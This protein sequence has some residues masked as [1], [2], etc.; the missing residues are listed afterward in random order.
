MKEIYV[1]HNAT[2]YVRG[3]VLDVMLPY[4][5]EEYGNAS[6][7]YSVGR[8]AKQAIEE[9]RKKV[10]TAI[11]AKPHEIYFVASGTE[12]DNLALKGIVSANTA[13]G[14]HIITSR[15][16]HPAILKTCKE[17]EKQGVTVTYLDVDEEGFVDLNQLRYSITDKTVLISIMTA[18][19]E[20]GTIQNIEEIGKI[21]RFKDVYFHTDSVQAIGNLKI[22]VKEMNID[23]L[24][25]SAH[26]FYGPKGIGVLYMKKGIGFNP[27]ITGR[28]SR[29][30]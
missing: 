24:S 27:V 23:A 17:L 22:D 19:N 20:I 14:S 30:K 21:A 18:N 2:T 9:A 4:F 13:K 28:A 8:R 3:E 12:A 15:I 16:E 6:S 29:K 26:K 11:N 7:S 25:M 1:D 5:T 10:A